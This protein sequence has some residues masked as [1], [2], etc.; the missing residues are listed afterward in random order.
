VVES[1][2]LHRLERWLREVITHPEGPAAAAAGAARRQLEVP[3]DQLQ[4]VIASSSRL[5]AEQRLSLYQRSYH[6]RL[7]E[8][9]RTTFPGLR[10]MLGGKLFDDF[11]LEY[12]HARPSRSYTLPVFAAGLPD[13]LAATR[14]DAGDVA[15]RWVDLMVELGRL[16]V[17][18]AEA[19]DAHGAEGMRI[20]DALLDLADAGLISC[21]AKPVG[22]L[23]LFRSSFAVGPYLSAIRRGEDPDL[24]SPGASFL[25]VSRRDYVVT[26]TVLNGREYKM[27]E[28][29]AHGT[30][31][32]L[33]ASHAEIGDREACRLVRQW[34]EAGFFVSLC[35]CFA[36]DNREECRTP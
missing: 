3:P 23:R 30:Q 18:V 32:G 15:E 22:C 21:I 4:L 28:E 8:A 26:L 9:V 5:S 16:E 17:I 20:P 10:H 29:L 24:A 27:L 36:T 35:D 14:P 31:V 6:L 34:T 7:L 12:I 11:A 25:A 33:A 1:P 19:Y 13:Y 2:E